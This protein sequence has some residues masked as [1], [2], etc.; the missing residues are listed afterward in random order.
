[1]AQ[2]LID[3]GMERAR[4]GVSGTHGGFTPMGARS[5]AWSITAPTP[6]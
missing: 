6:K 1:M 5:T 3:A 2:A 4:I